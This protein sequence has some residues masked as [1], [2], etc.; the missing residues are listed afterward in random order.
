MIEVHAVR[1]IVLVISFAI[2]LKRLRMTEKVIGSMSP[3]RRSPCVEGFIGALPR[4]LAERSLA[5]DR[6][7]ERGFVATFM[8]SSP[9]RYGR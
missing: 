9:A 3:Q 5:P 8:T 2:V 1:S 6:V 4:A 7:S